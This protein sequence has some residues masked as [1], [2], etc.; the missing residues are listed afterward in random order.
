MITYTLITAEHAGKIYL[1]DLYEK[2]DYST[3][4]VSILQEI[5]KSLKL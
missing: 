2:A 1:V 4:N 5:I 3:V